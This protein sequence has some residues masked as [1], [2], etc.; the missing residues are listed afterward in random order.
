MSYSPYNPWCQPCYEPCWYD[1]CRRDPCE[2][3]SEY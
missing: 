2:C 3:G 1:P